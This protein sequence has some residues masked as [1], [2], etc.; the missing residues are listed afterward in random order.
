MTTS[1]KPN[2]KPIY[3]TSKEVEKIFKEGND[4]KEQAGFEKIEKFIKDELN[5][6]REEYTY[7]I[8]PEAN[9]ILEEALKELAK[10]LPL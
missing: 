7:I 6:K 8:S 4:K 2:P 5:K 9:K 10:S 3:I 1:D